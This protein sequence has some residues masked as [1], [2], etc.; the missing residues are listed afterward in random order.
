MLCIFCFPDPAM[1]WIWYPY[2]FFF[3]QSGR[4]NLTRVRGAE[5]ILF[6][7]EQTSWLSGKRYASHETQHHV[8]AST[9][10]FLLGLEI[11]GLIVQATPWTLPKLLDAH[12]LNLG[13]LKQPLFLQLQTCPMQHH[14]CLTFE[15][16]PA[17]LESE[18]GLHHA[19]AG[20]KPARSFSEKAPW[21]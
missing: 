12:S 13:V 7:D 18:P 2:H 11:S 14:H 5:I 19:P 6:R 3:H 16:F 4:K 21:L 17:C 20:D 1:L 15:L 8:P 9:G 10:K